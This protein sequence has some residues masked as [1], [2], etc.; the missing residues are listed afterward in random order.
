[1]FRI[2]ICDDDKDFCLKCKDML[3]NILDKLGLTFNIDIYSVPDIFMDSIIKDPL[4]YNLLFVDVLLGAKNGVDLAENLR[5]NGVTA[6]IAFISV[7]PNYAFKGFKAAPIHYLTKPISSN[8]L[9]IV[10]NRS[11]KHIYDKHSILI[12]VNNEILKVYTSDIIYIEIFNRTIIIHTSRGKITCEG[13]LNQISKKL[14]PQ[15]FF[16]CHKSYLVNLDYIKSIKRYN[17]TLLNKTNIPIGKSRYMNMQN[18][19]IEYINKKSPGF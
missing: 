14:P 1:M 19:F 2:A 7:T 18:L 13:T 17:V 3:T 5:Q 16:R 12:E 8:D 15:K 11:L 10:I 9:Q 6:D 4:K